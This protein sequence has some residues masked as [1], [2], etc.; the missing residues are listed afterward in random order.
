VDVILSEAKDP[1]DALVEA[2]G[3]AR[4]LRVLPLL[5]QTH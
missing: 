5:S 4:A 2:Y 3:A 1:L